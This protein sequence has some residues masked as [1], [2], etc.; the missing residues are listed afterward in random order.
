MRPRLVLDVD[1]VVADFA[2]ATIDRFPEIFPEGKAGITSWELCLRQVDLERCQEAWVEEGFCATLPLLPGSQ[3]ALDRVGLTHD[4][5]WVTAP[6]LES[7]H[8]VRER[9]LWLQRYFGVLPEHIVFA[10]DKSLVGGQVMV[11]DRWENVEKWAQTHRGGRA[12]LMDAPWN[13][14]PLQSHNA[15]RVRGWAEVFPH[16]R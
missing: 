2:Q 3:N 1:G 15:H 10:H 13:Q 14:Q 7:R 16:L 4:I 5:I 11:D 6:L 8:W 9:T 12:L